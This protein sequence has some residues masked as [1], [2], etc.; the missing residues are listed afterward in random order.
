[1]NRLSTH[2]DTSPPNNPLA[3]KLKGFDPEFESIVDFILRITH[4]IWEGKQV[5]LCRDYYSSTCPVYSLAGITIGSEEVLQNTLNILATFPDRTLNPD[6]V[7][8][9][10]NDR[11]GFHSSHRLTSVM[12]HLGNNEFGMA[13]GRQAVIQVIAHCVCLNN[14][15]IEEWLVRDNY[16]LV[17]QLGLDPVEFAKEKAKTDEPRK[18]FQ[19]WY[20]GEILRLKNSARKDRIS[21]EDTQSKDPESVIQDH[22]HNIWNQRLVGDVRCAY[23]KDATL[24]GPSGRNLRGHNEIMAFYISMLATLSNLIFSP[25]HICIL[26]DGNLD[27]DVSVRWTI[28]GQHTGHGLYGQPCGGNILILG[29]SHYRLSKSQIMQEW[30]VFDELAVLETIFRTHRLRGGSE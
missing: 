14:Q 30:T 9:S 29:E 1:M 6:K 22:L 21:P 27:F 16:S 26:P 17:S 20:N 3:G 15:V 4:R 7:I 25:D 8:W 10:G 13:T 28:T 12:T 5:G 18:E 19:D 23:D 24:T 11:G 2:F